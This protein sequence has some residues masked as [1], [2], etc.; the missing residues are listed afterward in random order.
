[1]LI[2]EGEPS[3]LLA[4]SPEIYKQ[5]CYAG[6]QLML[7]GHTHGGQICLPGGFPL[8]VNAQCPRRICRGAWRYDSLQ[9]YTSSGC[10]SSIVP[11]RFNC[12]P[13]VT[14]H[15]LLATRG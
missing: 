4:H 8:I 6:F 9:G 11:A 3:I 1:M 15:E 14:I 2:P 10:G 12:P 5:A 7:C 13:E